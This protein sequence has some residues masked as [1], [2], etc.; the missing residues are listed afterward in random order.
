MQGDALIFFALFALVLVGMYLA[1]RREWAPPGLVAGV[2]MVGSIVTMVLTSLANDNSIIQAL[3]AGILVGGL[4][5]AATLAAAWYFHSN[6][7]RARHP[8]H[9][10]MQPTSDDVPEEGEVYY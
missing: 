9:K 1:I 2:G 8:D 3:V 10:Q 6:E 4:F 7:M 5:T